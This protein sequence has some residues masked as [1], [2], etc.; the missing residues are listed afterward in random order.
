[1]TIKNNEQYHQSLDW[2]RQFHQFV[3]E[4]DGN[5]SLKSEGKSWKLPKE[6]YQSKIE[7][8]NLEI[9]EYETLINCDQ[10]QPLH[11]NIESLKKLPDA[12]IKARIASKMSQQ[13]LADKLEIDVD[14]IKQHED[15]DYQ[16]ASF[17]EILEVSTA[18]GI[19]FEPAAIIVDFEQR[20]NI[21]HNAEKCPIKNV[22]SGEYTEKSLQQTL[23][24]LAD[25]KFALD[26]SSIVAIT[27]RQGKIT[28]VNDKFC[29]ISQ[30]SRAELLGQTHRIIN[31]GYHPREFFSEMWQTICSGKVWRGEFKNQAKDGTYYWVDT[32]IV[33]FLNQAGNPY[34][35]VAI[36]ND[37]TACKKNKES[38]QFLNEELEARVETRT[39]DLE[40]VLYNLQQAQTRLVQSEKMSSLGQLVAGIAHEINNPVNFIYGNLIHAGDY[41]QELLR[42]LEL[43]R[44]HYPG[45]HPENWEESEDSEIEF[46]IEDLPKI[47]ES[48]GVGAKRIKEIVTS[49][50]TFSRMDEAEIK[51]VNIHEGIDS[52]LMILQNRLKIK[53]DRPSIEVI[54][55]YGNLEP[56]ECYAGQLNQVFM[57]ILINAIDALE[58]AFTKLG[59]FNA[60]ITIRTRLCDRNQV[61]IEI[62]DNGLGVPQ[63]VQPRLFDPF[64]TTKPVGKGTGLG[65]SISYQIITGRHGG[66]LRCESNSGN[67]SLFI[68][69]IPTYQI[70]QSKS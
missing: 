44:Q 50:R 6:Y 22:E 56:I 68:I 29:E 63:L 70:S 31:S 66:T 57:N 25:V 19:K 65:L 61:V 26:Q 20:A 18:L 12:L 60:C 67:G 24:E 8:L 54:K 7:S 35:Y 14:I 4:F 33:P 43:Y 32:T 1:M 16:C 41:T 69:T 17:L 47:L 3:G 27:D 42:L 10:K 28:Y 5:E 30:Y 37:I 59:K 36:R 58:E 11:I 40:N 51:S 52:T 45:P 49:L 53:S 64:F 62:G 13:E 21:K 2:L 9:A 39:A 38:L 46:M 48:M 23:K 15:T 34:Q 55:D